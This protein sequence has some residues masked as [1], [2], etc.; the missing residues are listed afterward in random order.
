M[1]SKKPAAYV[2]LSRPVN[3]LITF[4]SIPV[5]C[6]DCGRTASAWF[7]ILMAGTTGALVA[8]GANAVNDAFDIDIDR[9]NRPDRPLPRGALTQTRCTE[10]V[11]DCFWCGNR[12]KS[13]LEFSR[14]VYCSSLHRPSLFLFS[15][16]KENGV[17]RQCSYWI[18]DW[19]GVHLWRRC[20]RTN[21]TCCRAGDICIPC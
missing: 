3:V 1:N 7:F 5:A 2:Q 14:S 15:P 8:A 13:F 18:D 20:S 9:I 21:R 12:N 19:H 6:L 4:V 17:H 11:A 16:I 10:D